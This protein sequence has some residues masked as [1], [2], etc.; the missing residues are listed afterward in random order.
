[1]ERDV[2]EELARDLNERFSAQN[3]AIVQIRRWETGAQPAYG[4]D[5]QAILNDQLAKMDEVD[6]VVLVM[7]DK[8]G[9]PTPRADSGTEE[10]FLR[11]VEEFQKGGSPEIKLYF[12]KQSPAGTPEHRSSTASKGARFPSGAG[13]QGALQHVRHGRRL[14]GEDAARS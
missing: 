14:P 9:R 12:G 13:R 5:G 6:L 7:R 2:V 11:A 8:F 3:A 4:K 10:E 1:M